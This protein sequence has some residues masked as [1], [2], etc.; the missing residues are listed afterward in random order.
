[1][2]HQPHEAVRADADDL[3]HLEVGELDHS[4]PP[5]AP[6]H[7]CSQPVLERA[8]EPRERDAREGQATERARRPHSGAARVCSQQ[9]H[10][11]EEVSLRQAGHLS[12][13]PRGHDGRAP[14]DDE[15]GVARRALLHHRLAVR[16][17]PLHESVDQLV[18]V[19]RGEHVR[20][21][22]L[23]KLDGGEHLPV[24]VTWR[25]YGGY[26][27]VIWRL[28]GGYMAVTWRRAPSG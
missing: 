27:A 20:Q 7:L 16:V 10:L 19:R 3:A 9:R 13:L 26:M 25:L 15:E 6:L 12:L 24:E 28:Y 21:R 23:V 4:Q 1:M 22:R 17:V 18:D 5:L 8:E 14:L 11:S 2:H